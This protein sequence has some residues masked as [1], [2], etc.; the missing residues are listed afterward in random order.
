MAYPAEFTQAR[1]KAK[2]GDRKKTKPDARAGVEPS[3][4][5]F[6]EWTP[7]HI[8]TAESAA[9]WGQ[10]QY[11]ANICEW[12]LGDD[13]AGPLLAMR[14]E[15]LLGLSPTFEGAG[16]RRR[17]DRAVR[18][19][20]AEDDFYNAYDDAE[21]GQLLTWGVLLG[22]A[23]ARHNWQT[24]P[25][26]GRTLPCPE[27][28]HPQH[29]RWDFTS[30]TWK[31]QVATANTGDSSGVEQDL[32]PGNGTWI[33]H[34]PYGKNRPWVYGLWRGLSRLVLLK[35]YALADWARHS[36]KGALL[37]GT[38]G[39]IPGIDYE[40]TAIQ[41]QQ[42]AADIYDRGREAVAVL[43]PGI[44]LKLVESTANTRNIYEAQI[45]MA[46]I[47]IAVAIR[48]GN[49]TTEVTAGSFA[50]AETQERLGDDAKRR[51]D[52]Q[53][54][55]E[56]LHKQSLSY[57]AEYNFGD[58]RLAPYP[59]YPVD[60]RDDLKLQADTMTKAAA[61]LVAMQSLGMRIDIQKFA[62][63]FEIDEF[64]SAPDGQPYATS[65]TPPTPAAPAPKE[66]LA[67]ESESPPKPKTEDG[68]S[69][70]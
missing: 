32:T 24:D 31:V 51:F 67:V 9:N 23:P 27:F 37:V 22:F 19:I 60:E 30:R 69:N 66:K 8:R 29:L 56:T 2:A 18:A 17:R 16:D 40:T 62:Q 21:L 50:A 41:R 33:L 39:I 48:G 12:I 11:A 43:P 10:T 52:G 14:V 63:H 3:V 25:K 53:K 13:R 20:E 36:E 68:K 15:A 4:R 5:N 7:E 35:A 6:W 59:V 49:L 26:T 28:W 44:D 55:T 54:L 34:C 38:T 58:P 42:L 57:W 47:A 1:A 65:P 61:A 46:N 45:N 64:I 70:Q